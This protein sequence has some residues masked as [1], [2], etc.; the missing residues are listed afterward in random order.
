MELYQVNQVSDQA[1]REKSWLSEEEVEMGNK[2][3][4]ENCARVQ[5]L[6]ELDN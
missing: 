4:R 6:R 5:Q 2:A 3:F 1:R